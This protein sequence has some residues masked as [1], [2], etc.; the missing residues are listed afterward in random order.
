MS[1]SIVDGRVVVRM[2]T[3]MTKA[4][5]DEYVAALVARLERQRTSEAVDL[6][7]RAAHAGP[8]L[9]PAEAVVDPLRLQ[10]VTALGLV[11]AVHGRDPPV[12]PHRRLPQWVLDA[13]IVHELA[14]L[15]HLGHTPEFWALAHRYPKTERAYGYLIAKQITDDDVEELS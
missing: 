2:P 12:R 14:H 6:P 8:A 9:R 4:Q 7:A 13:V 11:H 15:V 3:Y 10:P 5:E 1:A